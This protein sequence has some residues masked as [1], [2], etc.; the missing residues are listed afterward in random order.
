MVYVNGFE[1]SF[2][3]VVTVKKGD[4]VN[5]TSI[6]LKE[7]E[8]IS[9][10][11]LVENS[12]SEGAE[13]ISQN[14][15]TS[16]HDNG[17]INKDFIYYNII[18]DPYYSDFYDSLYSQYEGVENKEASESE[19]RSLEEILNEIEEI[20]NDI[21]ELSNFVYE[22]TIVVND[23]TETTEDIAILSSIYTDKDDTKLDIEEETLG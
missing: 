12:R 18:N 21:D 3:L 17:H 20:E 7:D 13:S 14:N 23:G 10:A 8:D 19:E 9:I 15:S 22:G 16:K 6:P 5:K 4:A 1:I 11:D 2:D